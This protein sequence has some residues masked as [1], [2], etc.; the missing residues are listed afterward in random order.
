MMRVWISSRSGGRQVLVFTTVRER[1]R[2]QE[3][4]S[5][6]EPT[7]GRAIVLGGGGVTGIAW[8]IGVLA[9]LL[10]AGADLGADVVFGTSAGAFV[11]AVLWR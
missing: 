8:K 9:G 7:G 3:V 11:G 2:D 4:S 5:M 1:H 6:A 10:D